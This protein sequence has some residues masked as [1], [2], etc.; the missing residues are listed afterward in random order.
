MSDSDLIKDQPQM[1]KDKVDNVQNPAG[2]EKDKAKEKDDKRQFLLYKY[3]MIKNKI[4]HNQK[5][6]IKVKKMM[7]Y[8]QKKI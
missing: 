2:T 7:K 6:K 5:K 3:K 8:H 1:I 4:I